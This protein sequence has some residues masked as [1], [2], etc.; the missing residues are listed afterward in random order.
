MKSIPYVEYTEI[1]DS[2]LSQWYYMSHLNDACA[3]MDS[4]RTSAYALCLLK[5]GE[6]QLESNLFV[7]KVQAPAIFTIAPSAIRK[8]TDLETHYDADIFFFRKEVFLK[9]QADIN[10]LDKFDFFDKTGQQVVALDSS[11]YQKFK[12]YFDLI[13]EKNLEASPHASEIIR[14]LIYVILNEIDDVHL[15]QGSD[16][17]S[18]ANKGIHILSQ[19]KALL[20]DNFIKERKVSFY[21]DKMHLTPK[22]FSTVIKEISSKTAGAW[23]NEMLLLESKVRLQDKKLSIAQIAYDLDFFDP[24]H[25]GKFFKKHTGISPLEYRS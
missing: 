8:F 15:S 5:N 1:E 7:Q 18:D 11:K 22:Y 12:T 23:I 25:F 16:Q 14:S 24:S 13:H 19:F 6:I 9:G 21:A 10:Y 3:S 20:A 17:F 4:H 2:N